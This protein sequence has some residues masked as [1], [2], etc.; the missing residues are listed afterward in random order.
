V[1]SLSIAKPYELLNAEDAKAFMAYREPTP[2][3]KPRNPRYD[4]VTDL[5][6]L[7]DVYFNNSGTLALTGIPS[8]C[9]SLC[10]LYQWKVLEKTSSGEW[11]ELPWVSCGTVA[12]RRSR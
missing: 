5:F 4:D 9:G 12:G 11:H 3:P 1:R 2:Q 6:R 10:A 7:N 8:W